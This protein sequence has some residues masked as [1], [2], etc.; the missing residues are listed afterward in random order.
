MAHTVDALIIGGGGDWGAREFEAKISSAGGGAGDM[1]EVSGESVVVG[2]YTITV[3]LASSSQGNNGGSSS[4]LGY[5]AIGGGKGANGGSTNGSNG[6]SGGAGGENASGG[7]A[8]GNGFGNSGGKGA[9]PSGSVRP[10]GGG[11]GG[12]GGAGQNG[13]VNGG[14]GGAARN[15]S[16][17]GTSRPY[18]GGGNGGKAHGITSSVG[19]LP[20]SDYGRGG[21]SNGV[22][23]GWSKTAQNGVVIIR[24]QTGTILATGGTITTSGEYTIHTFTSSGTFAVTALIVSQ[25]SYAFFM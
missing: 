19:A 5:T 6:G 18:C 24:Y 17:T 4:A 16:I 21:T 7:S 11:G 12:A 25:S 10:S 15:N 13:G 9:N 14:N 3:G 23:T 22:S 1:V 2:D 20:A 8:T